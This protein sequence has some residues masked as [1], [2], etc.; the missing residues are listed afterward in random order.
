MVAGGAAGD[1]G[2]LRQPQPMDRS[3]CH[4]TEKEVSQEQAA[5]SPANKKQKL[6]N[7]SKVCE[8]KIFLLHQLDKFSISHFS[9]TVQN[10]QPK[11][12]RN[13]ILGIRL[14]IFL[15]F[16]SNRILNKLFR[17]RK[18]FRIRPDPDPNSQHW[19]T[20]SCRIQSWECCLG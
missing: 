3:P 20:E 4:R 9:T 12:R 15:L 1:G 17:I 8:N 19:F 6:A 14:R 10:P 7:L 11:I 2:S 5:S 13:K 18:K 16:H